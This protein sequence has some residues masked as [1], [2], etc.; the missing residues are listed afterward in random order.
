[1]IPTFVIFRLAQV[2]SN[3]LLSQKRIKD[4]EAHESHQSRLVHILVGLEKKV[5]D[6]VVD[7]ME[8]QGNSTDDSPPIAE[9]TGHIDNPVIKQ[10]KAAKKPTLTEAQKEI[11]LWLNTLPNLKKERAFIH[12]VSNSHPVI[13]CRE[14]ERWKIHDAGLGI[15]RHWADNFVY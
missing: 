7:I 12:T 8:N 10:K 5:E 2:T 15:L 3:N 13:V 1:M 14:M 11:I 9:V 6:E 4:L